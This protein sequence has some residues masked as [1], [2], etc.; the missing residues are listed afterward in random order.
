MDVTKPYEFIKFWVQPSFGLPLQPT[1]SDATTYGTPLS[2]V[3]GA[4]PNFRH[5]SH[6]P[7]TLINLRLASLS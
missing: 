7:A 4:L 3:S 2:G 5:A 1:K 6:M